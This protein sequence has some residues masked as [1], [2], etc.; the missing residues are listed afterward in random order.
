MLNVRKDSANQ[1]VFWLPD[2]SSV[3]SVDRGPVR[4]AVSRS[5]AQSLILHSGSLGV[6]RG[7]RIPEASRLVRR[8]P[9]SP[10]QWMLSWLSVTEGGCVG[11]KFQLPRR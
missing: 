4:P 10:V 1:S 9:L 8:C 11:R 5:V 7:V 2:H 6:L 3:I